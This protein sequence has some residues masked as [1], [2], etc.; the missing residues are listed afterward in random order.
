M[1]REKEIEKFIEEVDRL[2]AIL[3]ANS[4]LLN[5]TLSVNIDGETQEQKDV[6]ELMKND[7]FRKFICPALKNGRDNFRSIAKLI[8]PFLL[9]HT[10][11]LSAS[12]AL[13]VIGGTTL[14]V[15]LTPIYVVTIAMVIADTTISTLCDV[16]EKQK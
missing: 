15:P 10:T 7:D 12:A 9:A 11:S 6:T 2:T 4:M 8:S 1:S 3:E 16:Y 13:V 14:T 5:S